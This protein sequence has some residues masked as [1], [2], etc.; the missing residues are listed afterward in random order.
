MDNIALNGLLEDA[1]EIIPQLKSINQ[2][3]ASKEDQLELYEEFGQ[4]VDRLFGVLGMMDFPEMT[5][6]F[7]LMKET[8]YKCSRCDDEKAYPK[9]M[10]LMNN[11]VVHLEAFK[12]CHSDETELKAL[13]YKI[14]LDIKRAERIIAGVLYS[15][16]E[17]SVKTNA[18]ELNALIFDKLDRMTSI[19]TSNKDVIYPTPVFYNSTAGFVKKLKDEKFSIGMVIIDATVSKNVFLPLIED[20]LQHRPGIP[21][22]LVTK[23]PKTFDA[24]DA[25]KLGIACIEKFPLQFKGLKSLVQKLTIKEDAVPSSDEDDSNSIEFDVAQFIEINATNIHLCKSNP[26]DVYFKINE[27]KLIKISNQNSRLS[28]KQIEGHSSKGVKS[29]YVKKDNFQD[30]LTLCREEVNR[31]IADSTLD[32][33][34]RVSKTLSLGAEVYSYLGNAGVNKK[35]LAE[36]HHFVDKTIDVLEQVKKENCDQGGN[37]LLDKFMSDLASQEHAVSVAMCTGIFLEALGASPKIKQN[38]V[39][40]AFLHDIGL[41]DAPEVVRSENEEKMSD[42]EKEIY[43]QHPLR[44][45]QMLRDMGLKD[46]LLDAIEQHHVKIG[47]KGFPKWGEGSVNKLNNIAEVIGISEELSRI[48]SKGDEQ[49]RISPFANIEIED[50]SPIIQRAYREVFKF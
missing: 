21:I 28:D 31:A 40:T 37:E 47:N 42:Q 14:N 23:D 13:N 17:G 2:R 41:H 34:V 29:Y 7:G 38:I 45:A 36:A 30:Y 11:L 16:R 5:S 27:N 18:V 24:V 3:L 43:Y 8:C 10:T 20:C 26:F 12:I 4:I 35:N 39:L 9:V 49:K 46:V 1:E 15:I 44:G 33:G 48:V 6:I 50:Y 19:V 22:A 25:N 32:F